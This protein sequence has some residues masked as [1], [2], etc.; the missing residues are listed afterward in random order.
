MRDI[1]KKIVLF[2][3]VLVVIFEPGSAI[4]LHNAVN[5]QA[6]EPSGSDTFKEYS[7]D[8][9]RK[10][11]S[12]NTVDYFSK[13][14]N[15]KIEGKENTEEKPSVY[16]FQNQNKNCQTIYLFW[17]ES[18]GSNGVSL[19]GISRDSKGNVRINIDCGVSSMGTCDMA[20]Y[21]FEIDVKTNDF[22]AADNVNV[23][24][25]TSR[26]YCDIVPYY[27][28]N[29]NIDYSKSEY[30][31]RYV[32]EDPVTHKLRF[33]ILKQI[34]RQ[35]MTVKGSKKTIKYSKLKKK[36]KSLKMIKVKYAVGKLGYKIVKP[37]KKIKKAIKINSKTG[38]IKVKKGTKKGV[39]RMKVQVTATADQYEPASVT[40]P[41]VIYVR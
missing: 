40:V 41:V 6:A 11:I 28:E 22:K 10:R 4:F 21:M 24:V 13:E 3:L 7:C 1:L 36:A 34:L 39:Y 26:Q 14:L 30:N 29:G 12:P 2:I 31:Y 9:S 27:D 18:S 25:S 37:S 19:E 38:K 17:A 16:L 8:I 33:N 32:D 5:V 23:I 20:Y 15:L 35:K